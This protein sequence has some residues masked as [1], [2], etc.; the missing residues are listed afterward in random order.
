VCGIF[1]YLSADPGL[2]DAGVLDTALAALHHRGPD[3][4]G[5]HRARH[6]ERRLGLAHTRLA[7]I[8]LSPGGH[9]PMS[10]DDGR[11]TIVYNGELYNFADVR[12]ELEG[13]GEVFRSA[14]DT[15]VVLKAYARWGAGALDRFRGMFALAIWDE[16]ERSLFLARDR[17]GIKPLYYVDGARGFAFASEVRALL[18]TGFAP[19]RLS[20]RGLASY[21]TFGAVSG[22]DT[23]LEGVTSLLPGHW[24]L[25]KDGTVTSAGYWRIPLVEE[26]GASLAAEARAIRPIL[27]DAVRMRLVA[28]VPVG[29][30]LSGGID[31]TALVALATEASERPVHTFTVTFDEERFSEAPYAAEVARR[32]GCDHHRAHLSTARAA[33]EVE[34][35]I[36]SIDQPSADGVNTYFVSE[37]AR[38]AGLRVALSGLGGDEV[39]AGYSLFRRF[40]Q[41]RAAANAASRLPSA[42]HRAFPCSRSPRSAWRAA[43]A[44]AETAEHLPSQIRKLSQLLTT[45]GS[46]A[47]T[48]AVLRAM[49]TEEERRALTTGLDEPGYLGV[50]CP[51]D[52][53]RLCEAGRLSPVNAYSA[54]ELTNYTRDTLL[55]DCDTM[56]MAHALEVRVPLLDHVLIERVMRVPGALKIG[57]DGNKP[58]LTAAVGGLPA[59]ATAR[60]KMGFTLPYDAWFKGPLR[61]WM[62]G[63]LLGGSVRRL[64]FLE[65]RAIERL[66]RS[67]LENDRYTTHGR[68]W[69][70]VVLAAWCEQNG[71]SC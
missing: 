6:G 54:L 15:E 46:W 32:Y 42:V 24:M 69:C 48:Y 20:R 25:W 31:S 16:R 63:L 17:L 71:V 29:V 52:L 30:F 60:Q 9:Q 51:P 57:S 35:A 8:D 11:L 5:T 7:I 43:L 59:A 28:D 2:D 67:F 3:D 50:A 37:A 26:Q 68:V 61:G 56:S 45:D 53:P 22:P 36:R 49:F 19:R 65:P 41:L 62:E 44:L 40:G 38:E 70:F 1:G 34:R 66:W 4:R 33:P 64:G 55:R 18:A 14:S 47:A 13:L 21:F 12:R 27:E 10:T 39:F 23:I 58:L